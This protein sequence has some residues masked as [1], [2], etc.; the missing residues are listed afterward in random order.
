M[1]T[2]Q[3]SRLK[4][5]RSVLSQ[6]RDVICDTY[7]TSEAEAF[8]KVQAFIEDNSERW[9]RADPDINYEDPFCRMAYVYMNVA[10]HASLVEQA[11]AHYHQIRELI[12]EKARTGSDLQI[13]VLGGGPGSELLGIVRY[14][15]GLELGGPVHLDLV[16][17]DRI[18]EWDESWH[19]LKT[20]ID[21]ELRTSYGDNRGDWPTSISRSFLPLD[22]TSE[23]DFSHFATRFGHLDIIVASYLVSELK[24]SIEKISKV[25]EL[26]ATRGSPDL[27]ILFVDRDEKLV[28]DAVQ[29][30]IND[31]GLSSLGLSQVRGEL[32]DNLQDLGEWYINIPFLP[33][34]RWLAFFH[35]A[36]RRAAAND[37]N[38]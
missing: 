28:R 29:K 36:K 17:V 8:T 12:E 11:L 38:D 37:K 32:E 9:R 30:I 35:L 15:E 34:Q 26:L 5:L 22:V 25:F 10:V 19:A 1:T 7:G 3:I 16:L 2:S 14:I 24:T 6:T 20:G 23:E 33:R 18:R 21:R 13:G 4:S 27:L 31:I